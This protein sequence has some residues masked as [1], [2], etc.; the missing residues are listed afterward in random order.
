V[1]VNMRIQSPLARAKGLGSAKTGVHHWWM[2]RLS[3]V[4]LV[5]LV[6]WFVYSMIAASHTDHATGILAFLSS[7]LQ[8]GAMMLFIVTGLYH[9]CLG[10]QVIVEDY[11][12]CHI[13]KLTFIVLTYF[14]SVLSGLAAVMAVLRI[15]LGV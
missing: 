5:P 13:A 15:H 10:V 9:G 4:A 1:V 2:Q 3:A 7:P 14:V 11:V 6:L 8:A 12:H